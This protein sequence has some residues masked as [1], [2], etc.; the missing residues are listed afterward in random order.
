M[1]YYNTQNQW[2][3]LKTQAG[4]QAELISDLLEKLSQFNQ[5]YGDLTKFVQEGKE[6]LESEKPV[7]ESAARIQEQM[8]TCQVCVLFGGSLSPVP[9]VTKYFFLHTHCC[10]IS[11][12]R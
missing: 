1:S 11:G 3:W 12:H 9:G 4:A 10:R 5:Q 7:G 2:E 8:K 6:L